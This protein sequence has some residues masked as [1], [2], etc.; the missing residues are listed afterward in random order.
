M[1]ARSSVGMR[2]RAPIGQRFFQCHQRR[3]VHS[4]GVFV[5]HDPGLPTQGAPKTVWDL[6]NEATVVMCLQT[7]HGKYCIYYSKINR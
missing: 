6:S 7:E 3:Q 1:G 4:A 2:E 5:C